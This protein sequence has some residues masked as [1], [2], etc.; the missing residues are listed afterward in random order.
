MTI[1]SWSSR[2]LREFLFTWPIPRSLRK[3]DSSGAAAAL[4]GAAGALAVP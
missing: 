1:V 3:V 4:A 2:V